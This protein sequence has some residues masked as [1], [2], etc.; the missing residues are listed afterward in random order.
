LVVIPEKANMPV[1]DLSVDETTEYVFTPGSK[2]L[3]DSGQ[4]YIER[5]EV[6][7]FVG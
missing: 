6:C 3:T 4:E 1:V 2:V 5:L 7:H